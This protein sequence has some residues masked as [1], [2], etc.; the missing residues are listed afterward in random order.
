YKSRND[1][2]NQLDGDQARMDIGREDLKVYLKG[3]E[4][5]AAISKKSPKGSAMRPTCTFRTFWNACARGKL[6]P[7]PCASLYKRLW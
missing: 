4:D 5:E 6:P 1:Q 7:R 2:L 3:A